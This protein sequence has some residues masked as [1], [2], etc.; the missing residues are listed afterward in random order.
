MGGKEGTS[1]MT[2]TRAKGT[3]TVARGVSSSKPSLVRLRVH[4]PGASS[5]R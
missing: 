2:G 3:A 4:R 1:G 5:S